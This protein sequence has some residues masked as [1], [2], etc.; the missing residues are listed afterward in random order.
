MT[1]CSNSSPVIASDDFSR[2]FSLRHHNMMWFLGAGASAAAGIPTAY[3]MIWDFKQKL[4]ASQRHV[5]VVNVSDLSNP[6]VR[7]RL[8]EHI[9]ESQITVSPG[10]STE[11][12]ELFEAAYPSE[13]D[14]R[15]YIDGKIAGSSPS[16]GHLALATLMQAGHLRIVWTT[17]FD[18]LIADACAQ[19]LGGTGALTTVTPDAPII[20]S[21]LVSDE[22]WPLEIKLHGDFRSRRLRN[23]PD[24]LRHQDTLLQ[25]DMITLCR[26]YGL[27]VAGYSGRDDSVMDTLERAIGTGTFPSGLFWLHRNDHKLLPRVTRLLCK[28]VEL[29]IEAA[30]VRI[31]NFD[32]CLRDVVRL[33]SDLDTTLLDEFATKKSR[34]SPAPK[35]TGKATWPVVR[36]NALQFKQ[37][38][39]H[40]RRVV[41]DIGGYAEVR[42]SIIAA[43]C[44]FPF[45][46]IRA[47]VLCFGE[48]EVIR[49]VFSSYSIDEFDFYTLDPRRLRSDSAENGLIRDTLARALAKAHE[50]EVFPQRA[51]TTLVPLND[52]DEGWSDLR[53]IVDSNIRGVVESESE[54]EW[55]EGVSIQIGWTGNEP[56]LLFRPQIVFRNISDLNKFTAADFARERVAKRYN[57]CLNH[58][59]EFWSRKLSANGEELSALDVGEGVDGIFCLSSTTVFSRRI[60]I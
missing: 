32:E 19:V 29:G 28:A 47:G 12:A 25:R 41:C 26:R 13:S 31:E 21:E 10:D 17:N 55:L 40:C 49:S 51:R 60:R 53:N 18:P 20:A 56:L 36:L 54:L 48:D 7:Q 37:I 27:I 46:R 45:A 34:W 1:N 33:I 57:T 52:D 9:N 50:M 15:V 11:Y 6:L 44:N 42:K 8:Q 39:A 24:E 58:L 4:Y 35:L 43:G 23:T 5:S 3:D 59:L 14:R 30:F 2:R 38:P 22:R 16:F